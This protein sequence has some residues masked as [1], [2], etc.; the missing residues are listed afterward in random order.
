[1]AMGGPVRTTL[2]LQVPYLPCCEQRQLY[3]FAR[4]INAVNTPGADARTYPRPG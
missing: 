2:Y 1:M 3:L 4:S